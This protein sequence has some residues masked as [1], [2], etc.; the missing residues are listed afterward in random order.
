MKSISPIIVV[1]IV[2]VVYASLIKSF[3]VQQLICII[4]I[5]AEIVRSTFMIIIR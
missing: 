2:A 4:A 5:F 1:V 3:S